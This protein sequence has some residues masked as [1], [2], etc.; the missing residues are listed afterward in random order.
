M[1]F[2]IVQVAG[3]LARDPQFIEWVGQWTVPPRAVSA[4]EAAQFIRMVCKVESRRELATDRD[5]EQRFHNFIR[6]PFVA[7]RERQAEHA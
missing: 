6:K 7:W 3:M 4:E 2:G 5:A 1:A